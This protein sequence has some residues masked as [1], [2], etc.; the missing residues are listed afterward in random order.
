MRH[1]VASLV[2][3]VLVG[4]CSL[5]YNPSNIDKPRG[6]ATDAPMV[7]VIPEIDAPADAAPVLDADFSMLAI[8]AIAPSVILE[9]QG[10]GGSRKALVVLQGAHI[11]EDAQVTITPSDN[12]TIDSKTHSANRNFIALEITV[13][14]D[15]GTPADVPLTVTVTQAGAPQPVSITGLTLRELPELTAYPIDPTVV[16]AQLYSKIELTGAMTF[17]GNL[18]Q[19]LMLHAVSSI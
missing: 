1:Y 2:P 7:D 10:T 9:G 6:D 12:I 5:I 8:T 15:T 13:G 4:G 11:S 16:N 17:T 18:D 3:T 14:I 19:R